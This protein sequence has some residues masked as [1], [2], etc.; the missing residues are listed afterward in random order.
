MVG[1]EEMTRAGINEELLEVWAI[2]GLLENH[3]L[4]TSYKYL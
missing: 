1:P 2:C 3:P 4:E